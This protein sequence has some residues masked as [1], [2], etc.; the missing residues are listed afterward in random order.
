MSIELPPIPPQP[1]ADSTPEQWTHYRWAV[2]MHVGAAATD[3]ANANAAAQQATAAAL[4]RRADVEAQMVEAVNN[5]ADGG[6]FSE[7]FVMSLLRLVLDKPEAPG[8]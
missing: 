8:G 5:T 7:Q 3:A 4:M 2:S 6:G 1:T